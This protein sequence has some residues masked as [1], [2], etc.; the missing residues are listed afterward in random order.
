MKIPAA[1]NP[2]AW[3]F[4]GDG[5]TRMTFR[6][7]MVG[8]FIIFLAGCG[9]AGASRASVKELAGSYET[10]FTH[11]KERITLNPDMTFSQVF[12]SSGGEIRAR[13]TWQRSTEFLGPTEVLL[14]G[15]YASEDS[16]PGSEAVYGQRILIVHRE[17]GQIKL[18]LNEA[19]DWYYDRIG[20]AKTRH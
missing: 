8:L 12:V 15:N 18:A 10:E 19:A 2:G 3:V 1:R 14:I 9:E 20:D 16:P 5:R 4:L 11:G 17:H 13:G 7:W 6:T